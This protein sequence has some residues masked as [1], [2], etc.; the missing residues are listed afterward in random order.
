MTIENP[1]HAKEIIDFTNQDY[2]KLLV[3]SNPVDLSIPYY[4]LESLD[5]NYDSKILRFTEI[6]T[7]TAGNPSFDKN[8]LVELQLRFSGSDTLSTYFKGKIVN[9]EHRSENHNSLISY[10]AHGFQQLANEVP[11][12]SGT[13]FP[14]VMFGTGYSFITTIG[15]TQVYGRSISSVVAE[16]FSLCSDGLSALDIPTDIGTPGTSNLSGYL[17]SDMEFKNT[18]FINA[19]SELVA[20]DPTKRVYFDDTQQ[21]WTFPNLYTSDIETLTV[22]SINVHDITYTE[23]IED[24]YTALTFYTY[25]G[26]TQTM[27]FRG[28]AE[29][30]P[31]WTDSSTWAIDTGTG[32]TT[33]ASGASGG[34]RDMPEQFAI[35][36]Q[37]SIPDISSERHPSF[38]IRLYAR[39]GFG[40]GAKFVPFDAHID[41]NNHLVTAKVPI[42]DKGNPYEEGHAVGPNAVYVTWWRI[43]ALPIESWMYMRTPGAGYSGS[44]Y[45]LY[46]VENEWKEVVPPEKFS[47]YYLEERFKLMKDVKVSATIPFD[48]DPVEAFINLNHRV[49]VIHDS[50][51]TGLNNMTPALV[52]Y[53]YRF[54]DVGQSVIKLS[55]DMEGLVAHG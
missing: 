4:R 25:I 6:S 16:L 15:S 12:V 30:T 14:H 32:V 7:E 33:I 26:N 24:R 45:T 39:Y 50:I 17:E 38:P 1:P 27:P 43:D 44:A 53:T 51:T 20:H 40:R 54:G 5:I 18:T 42:Y 23:D 10:T 29:C 22:N 21:A 31:R 3:A 47:S 46:N 49:R 48:G 2:C 37:W 55:T 35:F 9:A 11:V 19:V 41:L 13:G 28:W 36:R 34:S 52:G 8:A